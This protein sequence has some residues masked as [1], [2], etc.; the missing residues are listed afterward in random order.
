MKPVWSFQLT[1][2]LLSLVSCLP[3]S[4]SA[5]QASSP[6]EAAE[7]DSAQ[8][9]QGTFNDAGAIYERFDLQIQ[10]E[11]SGTCL[12]TQHVVVKVLTLEGLQ[13]FQQLYIPYHSL[14]ESVTF[15]K[16]QTL[17]PDGKIIPASTEKPLEVTASSGP[18]A[19]TFTDD[20]LKVLPTVSLQVGDRL[21]Y[22]VRLKMNKPL[23]PGDFWMTFRPRQNFPIASGQIELELPGG[24]RPVTMKWDE[25]V[26]HRVEKKGGR[27]VH[28][29]DLKALPARDPAK[30]ERP[31]FSLTTLGSWTSF[32]QW[33]RS[34]QAERMDA[35]AQLREQLQRILEG[36]KTPG[37][38]L[39]ALY[40]YVSQN[41]RYL[42]LSFGK[43]GIQSHHALEVWKNQYGDCKDQHTLLATLLSMAGI[44][45]FPGLISSA[46]PIDPA[47]P[48]PEQFDHVI[49]VVPL[50]GQWFWLDTTQE[51][52]PLGFIARELRGRQVLV[53]TAGESRWMRIPDQ[54][55]VADHWKVDIRG[56]LDGKG[57]L[58]ASMV[59]ARG[60]QYEVW[61]RIYYEKA[62]HAAQKEPNYDD[63]LPSHR[64][65]QAELLSHS[66]P[67]D[68]QSAF[69]TRITATVPRFVDPFRHTQSQKIPSRVMEALPWSISSTE[70]GQEPLT[71]QLTGPCELEETWE[72]AVSPNYTVSVPASIHEETDF[73]RYESAFRVEDGT[74]R[75]HRKLEI[76]LPTL[77]AQRQAELESFQGIIAQSLDASLAW[78]RLTPVDYIGLASGMTANQL[79]DAGIECERKGHLQTALDLLNKSRE[80]NPQHQAVWNN[81]GR[82]YLGI[83]HYSE[84]LAAARQQLAIN[85]RDAYAWMLSGLIEKK[86]GKLEAAI[87]S[88]RKA[89]ELSA[90]DAYARGS[91]AHMYGELKRWPEAEAEYQKALDLTPDNYYLRLERGQARFCQG[92]RSEA[93][94]DFEEVM[95]KDSSA[96]IYNNLAYFFSTC[97]GNLDRSQALAEAATASVGA[98]FELQDSLKN[99]KNAMAMQWSL[100]AYLDTL[101]WICFLKGEIE[102]AEPLV[103][104]SFAIRASGEVSSHLAAIYARRGDFRKASQYYQGA[105]LLSRGLPIEAPLELKRRLDQEGG[106]LP[107]SKDRSDLASNE[108]P[109]WRRFEAPQ[110]TFTW[111]EAS[112]APTGQALYFAGLAGQ[113]GQMQDLIFFNGTNGQQAQ[114]LEGLKQIKF[115]SIAW[116]GRPLKIFY[117]GKLLYLPGHQVELL[118]ANSD[119]ALAEVGMMA[120]AAEGFKGY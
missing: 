50:D 40:H 52:A 10:F 30:P 60:G 2:Y 90:L 27:I 56:S 83:G 53:L 118:F 96:V 15:R 64:E 111:P 66:D 26:P 65:Q 55:P 85:P 75:L 91:L 45:C 112:P 95:G 70:E 72:L 28:R 119:E 114:A 116:E 79:N 76:L 88:M 67:L 108:S 82:I 44:D 42:N 77:P 73:A 81:L 105:L 49:S 24:N 3:S 39:D 54:S 57:T 109:G 33:Y 46:A 94:A 99:W 104:A 58:S 38:K 8:S 34:L 7:L 74:L 103:Q 87:Q 69:T 110:G 14:L 43:G 68:F 41:I 36:K 47:I 97:N 5:T 22:E 106:S 98:L 62:R 51:L 19:S 21:E 6:I 16:L 113:A 63:R 31:L 59:S 12:E 115:P 107:S 48:T 100:A 93:E 92:K 80:K 84:A 35:P 29:W 102:R 18:L 13:S 61:S 71:I 4:R 120:T 11:A 89:M 86:Q 101:G 32:G 37:E 117:P 17:K 25:A 9:S 20:K 78:E 23:K 1:F